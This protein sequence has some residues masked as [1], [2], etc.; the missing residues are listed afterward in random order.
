[1][2]L[3]GIEKMGYYPTPTSLHETIASW[4]TLPK[5]GTV[6]LLDPCCGKGEF[7][8]EVAECLKQQSSADVIVC[9]PLRLGLS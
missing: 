5:S 3:E 6:R 7:E 8:A 1:M 4:L 9:P 2:R